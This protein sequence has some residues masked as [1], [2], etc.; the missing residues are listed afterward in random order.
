MSVLPMKRVLICAMKKDRKAILELLQRA[1]LVEM[2]NSIPDDEVFSRQDT[3]S[4][5]AI[6]QKNAQLAAQALAVLDEHAPEKAGLLAGL[7]GRRTLSVSEYEKLVGTRDTAVQDCMQLASLE[8]EYV[9]ACAGIPKLEA[10]RIALEPWLSYDLPLDFTGTKTT[11]VFTGTLPGTQSLQ[12]IYDKLE[13]YAPSAEKKDVQVISTSPQQTCIFV[14]CSTKDASAIQDALHKMNFAKPPASSMNP[15]QETERI[16]KQIEALQASSEELHQR[17]ASYAEKRTQLRFAEDYF[18]MRADKYEVISGL[19]QSRRTFVLEGYLPAKQAQALEQTLTKRFDASV[20]CFDPSPDEDVP[21]ILKNNGFAS[22]VESVVESYSLPSQG[23]IDPTSLVALMYYFLFGMMLGDAAYGIIM[24]LA[25][26]IVLHKFKNMESGMHNFL[27][28]FLY[29]GISTTVWGFLFGSFFGDAVNVI[30]KTFFGC[31]DG[32]VTFPALWFE[33]IKSPMRML[34]FCFAVGVFHLFLGLGTKLYECIKAGNI[35][36]GIYDCV[37]WYML[38]GG[39]IVYLLSMSMF[40]TMLGV[41]F[42]VPPVG[43]TIAAWA[44]GIGAVGIILTGGRESK[45]WFKRIL[46]GLYAVYGITGYLSDILSYSR[47][48]ALGLATSV[49]ASV[50]NQMG[51]MFGNT[52]VG[53]ILFIVVFIVGHTLNIMINA[54]G[55]Y[56]HTNRLQFVEFFGKFYEGG[57]RKFE[58]FTENTKYFKIKEDITL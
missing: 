45:N 13:E 10:Q 25:C 37:F 12:A 34:T 44:A 31:A 18:T 27:K 50:F 28:M 52:P 30:A 40:T 41:S 57:G 46:K 2:K 5:R 53:V 23:E 9:E 43:G 22:P 26:G 32:Q 39:A 11:A 38:V 58:P 1:G 29:C 17:I 55:A 33:P 20:E 36:D 7:E 19:A 21:V 15:A 56:V 49:I 54:L 24:V 8:K 4:A 6:F 16:G 14:I 42:T 47:L 3:S 48:L 35:L 51:S